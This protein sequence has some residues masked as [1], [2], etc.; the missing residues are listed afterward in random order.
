MPPYHP[1]CRTSVVASFYQESK[2]IQEAEQYAIDKGLAKQASYKDVPLYV[3]NEVNK[4]LLDMKNMFGVNYDEITISDL[5]P[6]NVMTSNPKT[7]SIS[8]TYFTDKGFNDLSSINEFMTKLSSKVMDGKN[9]CNGKSLY[10]IIIHEFGH[11][12]TSEKYNTIS[13]G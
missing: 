4:A 3:A 6:N 5:M 8:K 9:Y 12:L 7:L 11:R 2:T 1:R 13:R 10:D